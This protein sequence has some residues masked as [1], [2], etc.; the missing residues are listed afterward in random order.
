MTQETQKVLINLE[1]CGHLKI[2][3][4]EESKSEEKS[5]RLDNDDDSE[6]S[7]KI[8]N[9]IPVPPVKEKG[10]LVISKNNIEMKTKT[11][12]P[13]ANAIPLSPQLPSLV[14][15]SVSKVFND[16]VR[17]EGEVVNDKAEGKGKLIFSDD[18]FYEGEFHFGKYHGTGIFVNNGAIYEGEWKNGLYDGK[19]K[20]TWPNGCT[21]SGSWKEGK[22]QE[23]WIFNS[24]EQIK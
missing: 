1:Q 10:K 24:P 7:S 20:F 5:V 9:D 15:K 16:G 23:N 21:V 12:I 18:W 17:Y 11:D 19:G 3:K 4:E 2:N 6:T 8:A 22:E 14:K 13:K